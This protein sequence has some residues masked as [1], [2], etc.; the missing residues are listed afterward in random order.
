MSRCLGAI[1]IQFAEDR[2][3]GTVPSEL[4]FLALLFGILMGGGANI[5]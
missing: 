3:W 1:P 5:L 2:G 4:P